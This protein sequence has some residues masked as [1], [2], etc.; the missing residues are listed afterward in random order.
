MSSLRA[1]F[2]G[3][4]F[5]L[6]VISLFFLLPS[7][8]VKTQPEPGANPSERLASFGFMRKQ[9]RTVR[10]GSEGCGSLVFQQQDLSLICR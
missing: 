7:A 6:R 9:S 10:E 1:L 3:A 4:V 2:F 8:S 5:F